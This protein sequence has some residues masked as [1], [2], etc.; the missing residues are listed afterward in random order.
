MK[1]SISYPPIKS[2]KG[3]PLLSQNRQFQWFSHPTYI[4]P[5]VPA[6]AATLLSRN[7]YE[8]SWDDAIAEELDLAAYLERIVKENPDLIVL[9]SKTPVI[10]IHW[11]IIN[12]IKQSIPQAKIV[13]VGDH[14]TALPLESMEKSRVDFVLTGGDY[15]FL[16]LNL[17][18]HLTRGEQL[19]AGIWLRDNE[20]IRNTGLFELNHD[21]NSLPNIDRD[22]TKWWLYSKNNGNYKQLPGTYTM[23]G[24]DCW[25]GKCTFCSWTTLYS[26]YR[27]RTTES[28]LNE[29]GVLIEKYRVKEIFDDT[30]TFPAGRWLEKFCQGMIARGYNSKIRMGCNMRFGALNQAQYRLMRKAGF[31]YVLFGVESANQQT[32]DKIDK[33]LKVNDVVEGCK[34]AKKAGLNPHLTIMLGYPWETREDARATVELVKSM[35]QKGYVDTMQAT[36]VVPYPGTPLFRQCRE[37]GLLRTEQ[38]DDYDMKRAVMKSPIDEND[39][40]EFTR[41]LYKVYLSPKYILRQLVAIRNAG[42]LQFIWR[43]A[44]AVLGHLK[45]FSAG[46]AN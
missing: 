31:R 20:K 16:L 32:L 39:I 18:N 40:K 24:R 44:T 8:V 25:W 7:G 13:L 4:Y 14:V 42:D 10:Q 38:W 34:M 3:V 35:F 21:L 17:C 9:E 30:G 41:S 22:L 19:E 12:K 26:R 37:E 5:M 43:G 27:V 46:K 6:Y 33:N 1:I 36:I 29:I 2:T 15:D 28:L 11:E 23:A 45:D